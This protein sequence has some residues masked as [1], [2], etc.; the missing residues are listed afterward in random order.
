[1]NAER[2]SG[3]DVDPLEELR[4]LAAAARAFVEWHASTGSYG[5]PS[6][7]GPE[8]LDALLPIGGLPVAAARRALV[9]AR[10]AAN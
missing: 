5:L 4:E 1:M 10:A 8:G 2:G 6:E 7:V 9:E 3:A